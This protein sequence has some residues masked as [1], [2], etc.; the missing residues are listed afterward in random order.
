MSVE[1]L[2]EGNERIIDYFFIPLRDLGYDETGD[3][4]VIQTT[5]YNNR[6]TIEEIMNNSDWELVYVEYN[7][8]NYEMGFE[9][10]EI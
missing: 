9:K 8:S 10:K 5:T 3:R 7:G 6:I 2:L 1:E 4:L